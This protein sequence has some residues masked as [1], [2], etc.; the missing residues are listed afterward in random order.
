VE[1]ARNKRAVTR[2]LCRDSSVGIATSY[3]LNGRE[4]N[5]GGGIIFRT[6]PDWLCG[7][8]P[9]FLKNKYRVSFPGVKRPGS[10]VNHPP[11]SSAEV[12]EI[13]EL[14]LYSPFSAFMACSRANSNFTF[15]L[16]CNGFARTLQKLLFRDVTPGNV[17]GG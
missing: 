5:P 1:T 11:T 17:V 12:K 15:Y 14:Y 16:L 4:S 13:V 10:G 3:G 7:L 8:L 9:S 6:R 2:N